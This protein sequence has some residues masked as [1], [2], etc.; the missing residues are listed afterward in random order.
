M[1]HYLFVLLSFLAVGYLQTVA[2]CQVAHAW[3]SRHGPLE[4]H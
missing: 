4:I 3:T 1:E 2:Y